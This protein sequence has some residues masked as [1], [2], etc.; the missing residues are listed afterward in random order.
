MWKEDHNV[1]LAAFNTYV[2]NYGGKP[3]LDKVEEMY[4]SDIYNDQIR[5]SMLKIIIKSRNRVFAP[6]LKNDP[7][8]SK[9]EFA[10]EYA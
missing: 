6:I 9:P 4:M 10:V 8:A 7:S 1:I 2:G 3:D 5:Y